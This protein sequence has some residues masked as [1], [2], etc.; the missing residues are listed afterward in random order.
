MAYK[1]HGFKPVAKHSFDCDC[2]TCWR[3]IEFDWN[4]SEDMSPYE[5][6]IQALLI[7]RPICSH[8]D[9]AKD[10]AITRDWFDGLEKE[11]Y[12]DY[13]RVSFDYE[14]DDADW[15]PIEKTMICDNRLTPAQRLWHGYSFDVDPVCIEKE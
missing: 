5:T 9:A 13:R 4:D 8:D 12:T 7:A 6:M 3:E 1:H 15:I 10:E 14:G 11:T 2:E